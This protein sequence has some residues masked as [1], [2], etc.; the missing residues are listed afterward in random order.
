MTYALSMT[1]YM[2]WLIRDSSEVETQ[3]NS[4]ERMAQYIRLDPEGVL[5]P[6]AISPD[7]EE[8]VDLDIENSLVKS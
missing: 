7:D 6:K 4:V 3:M 8:L 5:P 2:L 1:N